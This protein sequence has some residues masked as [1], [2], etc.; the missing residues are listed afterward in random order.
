MS[1][2]NGVI[3]KRTLEEECK[4]RPFLDGDWFTPDLAN[5]DHGS[6]SAACER[7]REAHPDEDI[8]FILGPVNAV[9]NFNSHIEVRI[10]FKRIVIIVF[11]S[12]CA[13]S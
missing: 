11:M 3:V 8:K 1:S 5:S 9:S 13:T 4:R 12:R 7:C 2:T 6:V 10:H